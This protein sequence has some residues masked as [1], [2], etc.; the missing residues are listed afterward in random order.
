MMYTVIYEK[1]ESTWGAYVPDLPGVIAAGDSREEVEALIHEAVEFQA[2]TDK[3]TLRDILRELGTSCECALLDLERR[4]AQMYRLKSSDGRTLHPIRFSLWAFKVA[5]GSKSVASSW[6]RS[7]SRVVGSCISCPD[8]PR[9]VQRDEARWSDRTKHDLRKAS[10]PKSERRAPRH[11]TGCAR[12]LKQNVGHRSSVEE[13]YS[14]SQ[15]P[16]VFPSGNFAATKPAMGAPFFMGCT[17]ID[18][19]VPGANVAGR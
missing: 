5:F 7:P 2:P 12:N 14:A 15:L 17:F 16:M 1:G 10:G 19:F 4:I 13:S 6:V 18:T 3:S 9:L 11:G 8:R